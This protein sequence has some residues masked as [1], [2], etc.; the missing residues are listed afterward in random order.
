MPKVPATVRPVYPL[1]A[2]GVGVTGPLLR[3]IGQ[4]GGEDIGQGQRRSDPGEFHGQAAEPVYRMP[5]HGREA[6]RDRSQ[7]RHRDDADREVL[8]KE[9]RPPRA[10]A[11]QRHRLQAETGPGQ[12]DR[13][14]AEDADERRSDHRADEQPDLV[15]AGSRWC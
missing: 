6:E 11:V 1:A 15:G 2:L 10:A 9:V 12:P 13:V 3:R 14:G 7:Q 4:R 8:P 5:G